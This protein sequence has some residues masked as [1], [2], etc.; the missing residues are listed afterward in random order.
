MQI[1]E[2]SEAHVRLLEVAYAGFRETGQWPTTAYVDAVLD[3]DFNLNMEALLVDMP[4]GIVHALNEYRTAH[5]TVQITVAGLSLIKTASQ[6][7]ENFVTLIRFAADKEREWRPGPQE[8]SRFEVTTDGPLIWRRRVAPDDVARVFT[9]V[10]GEGVHIGTQGPSDDGAWSL[11]FDRD[12]RRY[13]SI[14]A[15]DD[16]LARLPTPEP[17]PFGA[18]PVVEPYIFVLMPFEEIWSENVKDEI[19]QACQQS[20]LQFPDLKWQRAD[21]ITEPGRITAQIISAIEQAD[22]LIADITGSN[23]NV[24]FELGYADALDKPI[25]VLNQDVQHTPFD[26]MDWRQIIYSTDNLRQLRESLV[27]FV[28][29]TLRRDRRLRRQAEIAKAQYEDERRNYV[30]D[31]PWIYGDDANG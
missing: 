10:Q 27:R 18:P 30:P 23:A 29:G 17:H 4:R 25:I 8:P 9:I 28:V 16:Y 15:I 7:L 13:R 2:L 6:D 21:D 26:I 31:P 12:I 20:A 22:L 5:S 24:L 14:Q 1:P 19:N 11:W 3:H